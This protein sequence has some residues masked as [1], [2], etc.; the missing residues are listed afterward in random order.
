MAKYKLKKGM[1]VCN[2]K[3]YDIGGIL[4][5]DSFDNSLPI[6]W[7]EKVKEEEP[8]KEEVKKLRKT[9]PITKETNKEETIDDDN[10]SDSK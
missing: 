8:K 4:E 2:G 3:Q 6:N 1:I 7:F 9:K 10:D 5:M